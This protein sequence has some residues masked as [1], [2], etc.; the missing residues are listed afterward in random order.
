MIRNQIWAVLKI[1]GS[2]GYRLYYGTQYLGV[3]KWDPNFGNYP[4]R[5]SGPR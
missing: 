1:M 4:Y 2:F 3:P 5:D